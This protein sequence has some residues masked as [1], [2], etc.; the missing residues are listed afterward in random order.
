MQLYVGGVHNQSITH[1]HFGCPSEAWARKW[2]GT[3][4]DRVGLVSDWD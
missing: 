1:S 4:S 3:M 2:E